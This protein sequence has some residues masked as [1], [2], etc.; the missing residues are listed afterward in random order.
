[1]AQSSARRSLRC[2]SSAC[3]LRIRRN[4]PIV[5]RRSS[6]TRRRH[7]YRLP[8]ASTEGRTRPSPSCAGFGRE[9][10]EIAVPAWSALQLRRYR[11]PGHR[12]ADR[13]FVVKA[14]PSVG[15]GATAAW[16]SSGARSKKRITALE[17]CGF[18]ALGTLGLSFDAPRLPTNRSVQPACRPPAHFGQSAWL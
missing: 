11:R 6:H 17:P 7:G 14:P 3:W 16:A 1:V 13:P 18:M 10:F 8:R 2:A 12:I 5:R 4:I 9:E 15:R